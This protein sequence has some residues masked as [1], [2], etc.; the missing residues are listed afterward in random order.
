MRWGETLSSRRPTSWDEI[1]KV[2]ARSEVDLPNSLGSK[3]KWLKRL[4]SHLAK[5]TARV[6]SA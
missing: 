6:S 4:S 2:V 1:T 5:G 3:P